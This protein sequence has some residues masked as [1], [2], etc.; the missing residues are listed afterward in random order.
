MDH[1]DANWMGVRLY[2]KD[3]M[4]LWDN[5][6]MAGTYQRISNAV[7]LELQEGDEVYMTLPAGFSLYEDNYKHTTFT[8]FLIFPM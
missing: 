8:G 7:A 5:V 2:H 6:P 4:I 1:R 3:R